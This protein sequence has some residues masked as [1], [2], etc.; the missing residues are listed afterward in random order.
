MVANRHRLSPAPTSACPSRPP[1]RGPSART[2]AGPGPRRSVAARLLAQART[3]SLL[4]CERRACAYQ[5]R[6]P[7]QDQRTTVGG[8]CETLGISRATYYPSNLLPVSARKMSVKISH[9]GLWG[10]HAAGKMSGGAAT[11]PPFTPD[12]GPCA[13]ASVERG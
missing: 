6:K 7:G 4:A 1:K 8:I 11:A 13:G 5:L 3:R 2:P 12:A 9:L 10:R